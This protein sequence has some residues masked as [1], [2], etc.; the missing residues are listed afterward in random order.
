M[1]ASARGASAERGE[2]RLT[3]PTARRSLLDR[4][5]HAA[6]VV[7]AAVGAVAVLPRMG[8]MAPVVVVAAVV[9]VDVAAFDLDARVRVAV[10]ADDAAGARERQRRRQNHRFHGRPPWALRP[11]THVSRLQ[12]VVTVN[13]RAGPR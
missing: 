12:D 1:R 6:A 4:D 13:R 9:V 3:R 5:P 10:A 11:T 2:G 7:M 8:P